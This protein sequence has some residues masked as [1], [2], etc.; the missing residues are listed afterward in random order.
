[1]SDSPYKNIKENSLSTTDLLAIG[2]NK[3]ANERTLL[4]YIRT[5]LS[6]IV[7]GVSLIQFFNVETFIL[8][9][10]AFIPVGFLILIVGI[11][12]FRMSSVKLDKLIDDADN[13]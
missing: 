5:F 4:A 12:R 11:I 6:F 8:L 2:R 1:M 7:A 13:K 9:G 3:L 10:Y